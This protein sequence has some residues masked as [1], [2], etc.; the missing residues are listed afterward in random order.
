MSEFK[1]V[2]LKSLK[3]NHNS[4]SK[5]A[6]QIKIRAKSRFDNAVL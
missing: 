4:L 3:S 6:N 1:K 5:V 2:K